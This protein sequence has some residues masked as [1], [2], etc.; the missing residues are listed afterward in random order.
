MSDCKAHKAAEMVHEACKSGRSASE[1]DRASEGELI[2]EV[3]ADYK[4]G[5]ESVDWFAQRMLDLLQHE[6][7]A[8]RH[9]QLHTRRAALKPL[10][11][12]ESGSSSSSGSRFGAGPVVKLT[13]KD[14]GM[15]LPAHVLSPHDEVSLLPSKA[16]R[17]ATPLA[18]GVVKTVSDVALH[19]VLDEP[20]E[21]S[22]LGTSLRAERL[23]ND[24][25]HNR[26]VKCMQ[27][28]RDDFDTQAH[29][30]V[31]LLFPLPGQPQLT[32]SF[33]PGATSWSPFHKSTGLN[34]EQVR[35]V[36]VA[37]R[38]NHISLVHGPPGTGKTKVVVE[39]VAQEAA[40]GMKVLL[41]GPSNVSVDNVVA[42]LRSARPETRLVRLGHP[43]RLLPEVEEVSLDS[44]VM[45]SD[46]AH[47]A[48]DAA[49][50]KRDAQGKA[51]KAVSHRS[52][53]REAQKEA[54]Q[55][56]KEAK[57]LYNRAVA[58]TLDSAEVICATLAGATN[59]VLYE[60]SFDLVVIDEAAQALEASCWGALLKGK[61]ALLAGDHLQLPPTVLSEHAVKEGLQQTL[62]ERAHRM[63]ANEA[64]TML[65]VQYRMHQSIMQWSSDAMYS[66]KLIAANIC[67]DRDL[68][69][70][71]HADAD[72]CELLQSTLALVDTAG[73]NQEEVEEDGESKRNQG[74][75]WCAIGYV[76]ALVDDGGLYPSEIG[77]IAPYSA[78]VA[79]LRK[80]RALFDSLAGL[81][82]A[83]VDGFQGRE[84]EVIVL[85]FT[86]SNDRGT[87]GFVS[88]NRRANV[89]ATR[90]RRHLALICD[91]DTIRHDEFL[92][93]LIE[94]VENFGEYYLGEE[95]YQRST[96]SASN[97]SLLERDYL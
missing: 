52:Q 86:R 17:N 31:R 62:F 94:H 10:W 76:L 96:A 70:M 88:D 95:F 87:V 83:T 47:L 63:F 12:S 89:A 28:L 91:A 41:C 75:A 9:E 5:T 14:P 82:I 16:A 50:E 7:D 85:S 61:R 97:D 3:S 54:R 74:E 68:Q 58:R 4:T 24:A 90:A 21:H 35:A 49:N 26:L 13:M 2:N 53:K 81:E 29:P 60:K 67:A 66:G 69:A 25:A 78:Q 72:A 23:A 48:L 44:L 46:D 22:K 45:A 38:S 6:H 36:D 40:R 79:A 59:P 20:I 42:R 93:S 11:L 15:P 65:T 71:H 55:L 33:H 32:P 84:K 56:G 34:E 77:V 37:I 8:E 92:S 43:A 1:G 57:Q 18:S 39:A 30:L 64:A 27:L 80:R 51:S 19:V 73:E